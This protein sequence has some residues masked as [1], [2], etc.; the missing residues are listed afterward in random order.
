MIRAARISITGRRYVQQRT[1]YY[2][3]YFHASFFIILNSMHLILVGPHPTL[4]L[5]SI[6]SKSKCICF[7][8]KNSQINHELV[9]WPDRRLRATKMKFSTYKIIST[10]DNV[11]IFFF[12][13]NRIQFIQLIYYYIFVIYKKIR[14]IISVLN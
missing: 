12:Y 9:W 7:I 4:Q 11:S 6:L 13:Q 14:H 10:N 2:I 3:T 8:W 1:T 5:C